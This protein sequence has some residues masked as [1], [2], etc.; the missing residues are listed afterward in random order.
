MTRVLLFSGK[1]GVG[2]TTVSAATALA[3]ARRGYRTLVLSFDIAHSLSDCFDLDR[4]LLDFNRGL[5]HRITDNLDMQEVEVHDELRRH[6]SDVYDYM[7]VLLTSTGLTDVVAEEVAIF[8][9]TEEVVSLMYL[10]R[11]VKDGMYDVIIVDC[12]PT[13]ESL[14]FVNITSTLEWYIRKRFNI[15]RTIVKFARPIAA[16]VSSQHL[17]DDGYFQ[18]L[19]RLFERI[20]G[21]ER[22]LTDSHTTTVR[23]VAS[24]EKM[25]IRE[26]QRAYLYFSIYGMTTDQIVMNR[27]LPSDGYFSRWHE[28]QSSY[29]DGAR[30]YFS[31]VPV[32]TLPLFQD[33]MV[34]VA[35]LEKFAESLY[36]DVDPTVRQVQSPTYRF[37]KEGGQYTLRIHVPGAEK[38]D[39][40]L[41]R[42]EDDLIIRVGSFKRHVP[43]PRAVARLQTAE[44]FLDNGELTVQFAER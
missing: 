38:T 44:A 17:P 36:G 15:D 33:E 13:G 22:V 24:A 12:P 39:I 30:E 26:T 21:I 35:R 42:A 31:P 6:W 28:M 10:N 3:S 4:R 25:V 11:Y 41:D 16:R 18:S 43:L 23:L 5:P 20:N 7:S 19:Q 34:G 8:P 29:V 32:S 1:G 37:L 14:R 2:K 27:L 40:A 9:G